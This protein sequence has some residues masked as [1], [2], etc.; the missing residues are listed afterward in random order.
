MI[1]TTTATSRLDAALAPRVLAVS[2]RSA[3]TALAAASW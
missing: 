1:A 3:A 2:Q